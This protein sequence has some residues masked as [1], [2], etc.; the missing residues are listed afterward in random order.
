VCDVEVPFGEEC[1]LAEELEKPFFR[2]N[3]DDP[4]V[5]RWVPFEPDGRISAYISLFKGVGASARE[6]LARPRLDLGR[7]CMT[8]DA[9]PRYLEGSRPRTDFA[10]DGEGWYCGFGKS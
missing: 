3:D 5:C 2:E 4:F 1:P 9:L 8:Q 7:L 6:L 10:V